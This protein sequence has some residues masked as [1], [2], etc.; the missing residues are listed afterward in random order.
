MAFT[1]N[2]GTVTP[3]PRLRDI[4]VSS[5]N[6]DPTNAGSL[7]T[8]IT[9]TEDVA[10]NVDLSAIDLSDV[11]HNGGNLT[12][13]WSTATGG[14]LSASSGGGVTGWFG[15]RCPDPD[16]HAHKP[17]HCSSTLPATSSTCTP[18]PTQRQ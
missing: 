6:D 2:D 9:V 16:R 18:P 4:T 17:Q 5:V 8:D 13:T 1:V 3:T 11:D 14:N 12:V 15:N 10:S 7:P